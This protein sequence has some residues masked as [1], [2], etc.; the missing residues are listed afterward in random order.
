MQSL[1]D[2]LSGKTISYLELA[3]RLGDQKVIRAAASANGKNKIP[4]II[5]CHRVIA[6]DGS[7]GGYSGG[8][9]RKEILLNL[10]QGIDI[11]PL[12]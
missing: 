1:R 10:E 6:N 5:P 9:W 3:E 8:L 7:I 12:F 4:I 11:L 2:V